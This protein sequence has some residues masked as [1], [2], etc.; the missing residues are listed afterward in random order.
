MTGASSL[1]SD[2]AGVDPLGTE[3][4]SEAGLSSILGVPS[5]RPVDNASVGNP[6]DGEV[7]V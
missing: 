6:E 4:S 7:A 5:E 2:R 3:I 1:F